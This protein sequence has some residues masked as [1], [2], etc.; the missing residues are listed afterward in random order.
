MQ[1]RPHQT[2]SVLDPT[3]GRNRR[4]FVKQVLAAGVAANV[5][6]LAGK[7]EEDKGEAID[8][9]QANAHQ[10]RVRAYQVRMKAAQVAF[11]RGVVSHPAN[12]DEERYPNQIGNFTKALPHNALGEVDPNAYDALLRALATGRKLD[13]EAVPLGLGAKLTNPQSG[14]AFDLEGPDSHSLTIPPAPALASAQ[15][16]GEL[17]ELYWMALA[18]DVY[19]LD[20]PAS[21]VVL[22]AAAELSTLSDF[23]GP[24]IAGQVTADT[25][26]RGQTPGDLTG[27]FIS[28]FLWLDIPQGSMLMLQKLYTR[29]PGL[30]Y[31]TNYDEWLAIQNGF[32]PAPYQLDPT[33]RYIRNLR[34]LGEWAH[35]DALYQAYH[36]ACLIL[37]GMF[38]AS[39]Q[40]DWYAATGVPFDK[41]N[42][43][44]SMHNQSCFGTFC[45][46]HVLSLVTEVA[47]RALKACWYQKWFVH[48]RL[49]PEAFGGLVHQTRTG[50]ANRPIHPELLNASVLDHVYSANG[51]YLL[52]VAI[53]EGC[54]IH[55]S[56]AAGHATVAG[57]CVTIL[58][59]WFDESTIIPHPVVPTPDGTT[60]VPYVGPS[61]TVGNE[62]N[63][64][65]A[66]VAIGRNTLGIHYRSDYW[67]SLK[68]GE[69]LAIGVLEEQKDTY[70]EGGAWTLTKFD[71]TT[72]TIAA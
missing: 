41:G 48:R 53:P 64:L 3:K 27:P 58:K 21:A 67:E 52:P 40:R 66:N 30:S 17:A 23:R 13:F 37:L 62:L 71:G 38:A 70:N 34:D 56:Y 39:G 24:K 57:A 10:R 7:A 55:P 16:A 51:S 36:Q 43:Y 61:L 2:N 46:P 14:L 33:P 28:Q 60:L 72:I 8:S 54:P 35:V 49:R 20:Y 65:A 5:M 68:L 69:A 25:V 4:A 9:R 22:A 45:G 50:M 26:F 18:R 42:P 12:G 32:K 63:K 47:S 19:V 44:Y 31:L 6:G 11:Q 15:A 59:A 1:Q 29:M